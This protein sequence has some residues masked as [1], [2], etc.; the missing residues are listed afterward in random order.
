MELHDLLCYMVEDM[1]RERD[2]WRMIA[3]IWY[4][5][6]WLLLSSAM[7]EDNGKHIFRM[8]SRGKF[9]VDK[10]ASEEASMQF[11]NDRGSF[12]DEC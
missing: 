11:N 2:I 1:H 6:T 4:V 10:L 9:L 12:Y 8:F 5:E 3:S 7:V